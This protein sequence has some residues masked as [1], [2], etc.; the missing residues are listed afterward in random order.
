VPGYG[1]YAEIDAKRQEFMK[2]L[3]EGLPKGPAGTEAEIKVF[4]AAYQAYAKRAAE[5]RTWLMGLHKLSVCHREQRFEKTPLLGGFH[6]LNRF[7][8]PAMV[9]HRLDEIRNPLVPHFGG[10]G[11]IDGFFQDLENPNET[12]DLMYWGE[13]ALSAVK[14][15]QTLVDAEQKYVTLPLWA[16]LFDGEEKTQ[17]LAK[18]AALTAAREKMVKAL[19]TIFSNIEPPSN[20]G[21][22]GLA[23]TAKGLV[24]GRDDKILTVRVTR[25][26]DTY[27]GSIEKFVKKISETK[28]LMRKYEIRY[29]HFGVA[30]VSGDR[31]YH[32]W[33]DLPGLPAAEVCTL[34]IGVAKKYSKGVDVTI[35]KWLFETNDIHYPILCKNAG[36]AGK[37]L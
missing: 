19:G 35:G 7:T 26:K 32:W 17:L 4:I 15:Y 10:M 1:T 2:Y 27:K 25:S 34:M 14:H 24:K 12:V 29:D 31:P 5:I 20:K 22:K 37:P 9:K 30:Y 36:A 18:G 23:G 33:P 28:V 11:T 13:L 3:E 21:D 16:A 8:D 6:N